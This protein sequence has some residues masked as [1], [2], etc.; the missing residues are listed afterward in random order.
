MGRFWR[1]LLAVPRWISV[2]IVIGIHAQA[3]TDL[4][5]VAQAFHDLRLL[6]RACQRRQEQSRQNGNDRDDDKQFN[7][8]EGIGG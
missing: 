2:A 7:Q 8:V 3:E 5:K 4:P 1:K 6:L